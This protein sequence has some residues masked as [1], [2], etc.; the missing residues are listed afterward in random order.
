MVAGEVHE[1]ER[2]EEEETKRKRSD[3]DDKLTLEMYA[4]TEVE[5]KTIC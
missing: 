3:S 5:L 1:V 4:A 2:V